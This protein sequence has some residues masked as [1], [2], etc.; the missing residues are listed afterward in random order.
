MNRFAQLLNKILSEGPG[1]KLDYKEAGEFLQCVGFVRR[2]HGN[3]DAFVSRNAKEII[4]LQCDGRRLGTPVKPY[5]LKLI[6]KILIQY[7][8]RRNNG[9]SI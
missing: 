4:F 9:N 3:I 5:H 8:K 7:H 1:T 2:N 6:R